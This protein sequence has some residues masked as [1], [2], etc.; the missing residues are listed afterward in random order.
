MI[1]TGGE[2]VSADGVAS[3]LEDCP[4]V[5][6]AVVVGRPDPSGVS[7]SPRS[8][9]PRTPRRPR[10]GGAARVRPRQAAGL[11]G[12]AGGRRG[13]G[14]PA[15]VLGQARPAGA[16]VAGQQAGLTSPARTDQPGQD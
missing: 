4:G 10:A 9:W 3:V 2:K 8:W 14:R 11:R 6:E 16:P 13:A 1:N 12:A 15:A 5:R 7:W